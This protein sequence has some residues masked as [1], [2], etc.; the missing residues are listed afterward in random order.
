MMRFSLDVYPFSRNFSFEFGAMNCSDV[1]YEFCQL[2]I[3]KEKF[4]CPQ[5]LQRIGWIADA[6]LTTKRST[7]YVFLN[8]F[9]P[10]WTWPKNLFVFHLISIS[11]ILT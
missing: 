7:N 5:K 4:T 2:S 10:I 6:T 1:I 9:S 8:I 11:V 3:R